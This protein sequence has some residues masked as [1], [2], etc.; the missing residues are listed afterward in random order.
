[1]LNQCDLALVT[2]NSAMYGLGVPSKTYNNME[3]GK[4]VL[5]IGPEKS[6][7]YNEVINNDITFTFDD[8]DK[9]IDFLQNLSLSDK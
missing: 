3:A 6:E 5:F 8:K 7:I 1:M 4:P 2:L 9:I